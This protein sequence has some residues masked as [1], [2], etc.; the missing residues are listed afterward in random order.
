MDISIYQLRK[1]LLL[2]IFINKG[3]FISINFL[4]FLIH[5]DSFV[6]SNENIQPLNLEHRS[7]PLN[8]TQQFNNFQTAGQGQINQYQGHYNN[9]YAY[10]SNNGENYGNYCQQTN[11]R[12]RMFCSTCGQEF[13]SSVQLNQHME[14]H[15]CQNSA[16]VSDNSGLNSN[17][18]N[19]V[20]NNMDNGETSQNGLITNTIQSSEMHNNMVSNANQ[21]KWPNQDFNGEDFGLG[22][23]DLGTLENT[24]GNMEDALE[25]IQQTQQQQPTE[26]QSELEN[27]ILNSN[28]EEVI[29]E[30]ISKPLP[31]EMTNVISANT[32]NST[33]KTGEPSTNCQDCSLTFANPLDLKKHLDLAHNGRSNLH[34]CKLCGAEFG[35]KVEYKEHLDGHAKEKPFQCGTCGLRMASQSMLN[36]HIK[37]V[38]VSKIIPCIRFKILLKTFYYN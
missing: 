18:M 16:L 4:F 3:Q 23:Q 22:Y 5:N 19:R 21:C 7:S 25:V 33:S 30:P 10:N 1:D 32:N 9:F 20:H 34:H 11:G 26:I 24:A 15:N 27:I 36:R 2:V 28:S 29:Q 31:A 14:R 35:D 13:A 12:I 8:L 17:V 37:R 6:L 38:S